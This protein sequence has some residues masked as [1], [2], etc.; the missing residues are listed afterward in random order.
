MTASSRSFH[1]TREVTLSAGKSIPSKNNLRPTKMGIRPVWGVTSL[2]SD[3]VYVNSLCKLT[4]DF[5]ILTLCII[6]IVGV[7]SCSR[8]F[9]LFVLPFS[10]PDMSAVSRGVVSHLLK[11][12]IVTLRLNYTVVH[13]F[14]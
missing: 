4:M 5:G 2:T 13:T 1:A 14:L 10:A 12:P 9:L 7:E 6:Q 3:I 11:S 8:Y